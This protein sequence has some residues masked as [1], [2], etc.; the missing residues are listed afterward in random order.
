MGT[1]C[2]AL[3]PIH[4]SST[5]VPRACAQGMLHHTSRASVASQPASKC[6]HLFM[7]H[8]LFAD[9]PQL[10][11]AMGNAGPRARA[12]ADVVLGSTN[13]GDGVA[14]AIER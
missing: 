1:E 11:V 13:D 14:D 2:E 7:L 6:D 12:A 5:L 10:G 9:M 4:S 8:R 3:L